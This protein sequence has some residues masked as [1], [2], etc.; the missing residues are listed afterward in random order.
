MAGIP[1]ARLEDFL[2][3][4]VRRNL[5]MEGLFMHRRMNVARV[6]LAL[7]GLGMWVGPIWAVAF[8][9]TFT[10]IDNPSAGSAANQGTNLTAVDGSIIVGCYT[11]P[12]NGNNYGFVYSGSTFTALDGPAG[13]TEC[14]PFGINGGNIVGQYTTTQANG[15]LYNGSTYT[16]IDDPLGTAGTQALGISG[17]NIVGFY[18]DSAYGLHGFLYNGSTYTPIDDP[19]AETGAG[20][21]TVACG[22]NGNNVVGYY[23][24]ADRDHGFLYNG[25]TFQ[26]LD[27]PLATSGTYPCGIQGGDIVGYYQANGQN[28]GFL[29][30]GST[31]TTIDDP[32]G[33]N[34][35]ISG[36]S[37]DTL[38]GTYS[39]S[40]GVSHGFLANA[41]VPGDAT[42]DGTVDVNDLAIV[43]TN[44]G[45]S[46]G[47]SWTTGDFT[48]DGTVD[49]NDLKIVLASFGASVSA[50]GSSALSAVPEP[51]ALVL[52]AA[53]LLVLLPR[54]RRKLS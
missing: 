17:G 52:V 38:V 16:T 45:Q 7:V 23:N 3:G 1:A 11:G 37:G 29:Y 30:N 5:I 20:Y 49:I 44:F 4:T 8:T 15:F 27:D 12:S 9:N 24:G 18:Q 48:G 39:D 51:C 6:V 25:S 19:L 43:A 47:M 33:V 53:V 26:P 34:T 2:R 54:A 36:I 14:Q 42:G 28:H 13:A 10:T 22:I 50:P 46:T 40:E 32:A 35:I 21:G 41:F 31:Y